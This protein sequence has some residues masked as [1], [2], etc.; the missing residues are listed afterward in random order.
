MFD[1]VFPKADR[2]KPQPCPQCGEPAPQILSAP[3]VFQAAHPDGR[4][5]DGLRKLADASRI[6]ADSFNLPHDQRKHHDKAIREL[7]EIKK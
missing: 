4:R 1:L 7:T 2:G 5:D 3:A 6:E